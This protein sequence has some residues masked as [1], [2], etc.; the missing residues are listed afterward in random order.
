M[1]NQMTLRGPHSWPLKAEQRPKGDEMTF[2]QCEKRSKSPGEPR[3][4]MKKSEDT[5]E[6]RELGGRTAKATA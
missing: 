1:D 3:M 5:E 4:L 6:Q 2:S